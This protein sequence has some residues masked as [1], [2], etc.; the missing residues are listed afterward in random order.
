MWWIKTIN[1]QFIS[2]TILPVGL[3]N[4]LAGICLNLNMVEH[5]DILVTKV[6]IA[7]LCTFLKFIWSY[8]WDKVII[9]TQIFVSPRLIVAIPWHFSSS[10]GVTDVLHIIIWYVY[11]PHGNALL[12]IIC[13]SELP[14]VICHKYRIYWLVLN[15]TPI[16]SPQPNHN[17]LITS[18]SSKELCHCHECWLLSPAA[19]KAR[20]V[21]CG[22]EGP[23]R[24]I[25]QRPPSVLSVCPSVLS[26][27]AP[28]A[29]D[30]RYCNAPPVRLFVYPS[31]CL[32]FLPRR[33]RPGTGDI[34][35]PPVRLSVCPSVAFSF[36]T[37]T[38]KRIQLMYFLKTFQVR[39][40]C[41]GGVLYSFGYWW[42]VVL[43]IEKNKMLRIF[44]FNI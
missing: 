26:P 33:Q 8:R 15:H 22:A 25:L 30:G 28:K 19:P 3:V 38:R 9:A 13:F 41:H 39:A 42:N 43:N 2:Q 14:S 17:R 27:A 34:A 20:D 4:L 10:S 21:S 7:I 36:R 6:I 11:A 23:G 16:N 32:S 40:P 37:V 29:R 24:E 1:I 35:T 12:N 31:I 5:T 44:F 18:V